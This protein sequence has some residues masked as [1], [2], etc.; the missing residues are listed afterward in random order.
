M[1]IRTWI[2]A[3][4]ILLAG[5]SGQNNKSDVP[6]GLQDIVISGEIK[7]GGDQ[8]LTL[9]RIGSSSFIP[10]AS[11]RCEKDGSFTITFSGV[12]L[13]Y[14]ALKFTDQGYITIIASPG[15]RITVKGTAGEIYPYNI[16][17]SEASDLVRE[18]SEEHQAAMKQLHTISERT[19]ELSTEPGF[20][21]KKME[22]N[23]RFDSVTQA[24]HNYSR[25]FIMNNSVSPAILIALYNQFGP[26]LPVFD[27]VSDMEI[28]QLVDSLMYS[29]YP[30]NEAVKS[31]HSQLSAKLQQMRNQQPRQ[32]LG[33]GNRA[34]DFVLETPEKSK[35]SLSEMKGNYVLL[36]FWASWSNPSVSEN[37]YLEESYQKFR[38]KNFV[39]LQASID[40]DMARWKEALGEKRPGWY[41]VSDL[42]RWESVIV[43]LYRVEK[44]PANFLIGPDGTILETDTFGE[45]LIKTIE[46]YLS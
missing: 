19:E 9:D 31:L 45:E 24:F 22:L 13:D 38:D 42:M 16:E 1:S 41:H 2:I 14:Y 17:G 6:A 32:T 30:E 3:G 4:F 27:P 34:P 5:C 10:V 23:A 44:I 11:T 8:L 20:A 33:K 37:R 26:G 7:N 15:D 21:N 25:D 43:N 35:V 12:V 40:N 18:L 39:I 29:Q 46:K 36:Q 28:Y